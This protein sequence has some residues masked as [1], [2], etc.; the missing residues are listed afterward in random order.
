MLISSL[1]NQEKF[2]LVNKYG[3]KFHSRSFLAVVARNFSQ[4]PSNSPNTI[5]LG[6]KVNKKLGNAVTRNKIKRRIRHLIRSLSKNPRF[7]EGI[8]STI[9]VPRKG[10]EKVIFTSLTNEFEKILLLP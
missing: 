10:F 5:F 8:T 6:M 2:D 4:I 7:S 9:I 1:K 3:S